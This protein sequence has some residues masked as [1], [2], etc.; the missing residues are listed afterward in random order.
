[1]G[2]SCGLDDEPAQQHCVVSAAPCARNDGA[3]GCDQD[4]VADVDLVHVTGLVLRA[5]DATEVPEKTVDQHFGCPLPVQVEF[6]EMECLTCLLVQLMRLVQL[7]VT[8]RNTSD[9]L[10]RLD[11]G[12][13]NFLAAHGTYHGQ[14]YLSS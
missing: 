12:R 5:L 11:N 3:R 13:S 4:A 8:V 14:T 9:T 7:A 1:M 6:R 10:E 2:T